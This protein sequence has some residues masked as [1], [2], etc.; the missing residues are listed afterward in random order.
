MCTKNQA[1]GAV[2]RNE[3]PKLATFLNIS[4][5]SKHHNFYYFWSFTKLFV[6][7]SV[8][9]SRT[10]VCAHFWGRTARLGTSYGCVN[11]H[12]NIDTTMLHTYLLQVVGVVQTS[13]WEPQPS[14]A[15]SKTSTNDSSRA[16]SS[17]RYQQKSKTA[18]IKKVTVFWS[19][20]VMVD[21]L[22]ISDFHS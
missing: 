21:I 13:I 5:T 20:N 9:C 8:Y 15:N 1:Y 12:H 10:V 3:S 18:K 4:Q 17:S 22:P 19:L 2:S 14:W 11:I 7:R 6:P 16:V